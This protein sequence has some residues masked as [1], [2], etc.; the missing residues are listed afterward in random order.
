MVQAP[1]SN[2]VGIAKRRRRILTVTILIVLVVEVGLAASA[3]MAVARVEPDG[4][5][6]QHLR[7]FSGSLGGVFIAAAMLAQLRAR[8]GHVS[9]MQIAFILAA[10][11]A[12]GWSTLLS[13]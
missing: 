2:P 6:N 11:G 3:L 7:L 9:G 4:Y 12:L 5:H 8:V 13:K 1:P 10:L